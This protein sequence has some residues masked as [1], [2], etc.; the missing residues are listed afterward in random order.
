MTTI[1]FDK[2]AF[3]ESLRSAG[4]PEDHARAHAQALDA[5]LHDSVATKGDVETL[6]LAVR[7]DLADT[8]AD[9][10]KSV[11]AM[12]L[13]AVALNSAVVLGGM[14]GLAKLLGH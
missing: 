1:T 2:L 12:L 11:M 13:A 4:I 7:A 10:L 9:I 8:K 14:I 5:A 6:R 3:V